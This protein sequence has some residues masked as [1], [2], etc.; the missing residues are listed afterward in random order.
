V[1]YGLNDI[2]A[3]IG[4]LIQEPKTVKELLESL[5]E[6]YEVTLGRCEHD[7]LALLQEM[8]GTGLIKVKNETTA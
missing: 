1:Y 6:E 7:L 4:N 3:Q 5:L 8:A 2:G